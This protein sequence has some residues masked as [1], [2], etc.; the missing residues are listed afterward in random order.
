MSSPV[1]LVLFNVCTKTQLWKKKNLKQARSSTLSMPS[2]VQRIE[3][4]VKEL[5]S[6]DLKLRVRVL[7]VHINPTPS[8][9]IFFMLLDP[10][11]VVY[12]SSSLR[13]SL[14][15]LNVF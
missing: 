11:I 8:K 12:E 2:R 4:F 1:S 5:D 6:G 9:I 10:N 3:E 13:I 14:S 7:E 15:F